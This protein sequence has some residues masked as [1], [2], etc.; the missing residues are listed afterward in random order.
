M[1]A[2]RTRSFKITGPL[3]GWRAHI[4]CCLRRLPNV[5][6]FTRL[7]SAPVLAWLILRSRFREAL[8]LAV[9]AGISDW[10]DG[11]AARRLGTSGHLGVVLDPLADK[12]LLVTLFFVLTAVG[13]IPV[14]LTALVFGRDVMIVVGAWLLRWLR[15]PRQFLPSML[16][17]ISTFFQI[18]LILAV[19]LYAVF[20]GEL[21]H[22]LKSAGIVVTTIF[23]GLSG[24]DYVRRGWRMAARTSASLPKM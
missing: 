21:L 5:L 9:V 8:M 14:W 23:T 19:L 22:V 13:L 7:L 2:R 12:V 1:S 3:Y 6:T 20:A 10:L 15:G 18:M 16:G 17:K 24:A 4:R 11:V